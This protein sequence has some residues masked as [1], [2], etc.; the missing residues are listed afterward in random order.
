[1]CKISILEKWTQWNNKYEYIWS[2]VL[3]CLVFASF[4]VSDWVLGGLSFADYGLGLVLSCLLLSGMYSIKLNQYKWIISPIGIIVLNITIHTI[5]DT[6]FNTILGLVSLVK[7]TF[8]I[9][10]ITGLYNYIRKYQR[11]TKL[12]ILL[13]WFAVI[14]CLIG[15]YITIALYSEGML[16]YKF[17][18]QFTRYDI[19]SYLFES[20]PQIIRTRSLF[21]EPAHFGYF[22]NL[23]LSLNLFSRIKFNRKWIFN[24]ILTF[25]IFI[26]FSYSMIGIMLIVY[27]LMF[28]QKS[29]KKEIIWNNFYWLI[30]II[31]IIVLLFFWEYI[32]VTLIDRTISLISGE[33]VS[34]RMRLIE[35]WQYV[36]KS[37]ILMGNGIGHTPVITNN[38][39]Y[40]QSDLG[41]IATSLSLL[42]TTYILKK[43]IGLGVIFVLL[44]ITRGGYLGPAYWLVIFCITIFLKDNSFEKISIII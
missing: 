20:N 11:E 37:N 19:Y 28:I 33:D 34:A 22:L 38:Y 40:F 9:L 17:L 16:P 18:W 14:S 5:V 43:N 32:E 25:G 6:N 8:Y 4:L 39:A 3:I 1:M 23:I 31:F 44:N 29:I 35:S 27:F 12:L 7:I 42:A 24:F 15:I 41:I 13:N 26:T 21:S 2:S 30:I 36:N 10:V